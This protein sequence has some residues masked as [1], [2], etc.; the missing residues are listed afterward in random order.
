MAAVG[1]FARTSSGM[2]GLLACSV[3]TRC[4]F[5]CTDVCSSRRIAEVNCWLH[6]CGGCCCWL[7]PRLMPLLLLL[8]LPSPSSSLLLL[9]WWLQLLWGLKLLSLLVELSGLQKE[10]QTRV[11]DI[12]YY[13]R[14]VGLLLLLL[15]STVQLAKQHFTQTRASLVFPSCGTWSAVVTLRRSAVRPQRVVSAQVATCLCT[16]SNVSASGTRTRD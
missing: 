1:S 14:R 10:L 9:L 11:R 5:T 8:L 3:L 7:S 13:P 16:S 12:E 2:R 4:S 6:T 15:L